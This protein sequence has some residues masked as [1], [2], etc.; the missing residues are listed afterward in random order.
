MHSNFF[1]RKTKKIGILFRYLRNY[2]YFCQRYHWINDS[3]TVSRDTLL[4][5]FYS[6]ISLSKV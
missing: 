2:D 6:V 4:L 3:L 5:F 1:A